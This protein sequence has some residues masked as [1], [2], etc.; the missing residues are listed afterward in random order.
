MCAFYTTYTLLDI[1][2]SPLPVI[3]H[4]KE[5]AKGLHNIMLSTGGPGYT[6]SIGLRKQ[7]SIAQLDN[8]DLSGN[9]L[10]WVNSDCLE[11]MFDALFSLPQLSSMTLELLDNF[12]NVAQLNLLCESWDKKAGG[13]RLSMLRV[14]KQKPQQ[15]RAGHLGTVPVGLQKLAVI[16]L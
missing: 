16:V 9:F 7:A 2:L 5:A 4:I 11:A 12:F 8:L 13:R 14:R 3:S 10:T 15:P 6:P 1:S